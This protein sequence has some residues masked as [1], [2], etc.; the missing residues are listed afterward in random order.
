[1]ASPK[2]TP[3]LSSPP[4]F[5]V[6][7][8]DER[9]MELYEQITAIRTEEMKTVKQFI[10]VCVAEHLAYEHNALAQQ[11]MDYLK[12]PRVGRPRK[13]LTKEDN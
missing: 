11:I 1:M 2:P 6:R 8:N 3:A 13:Q 7:L 4:N 5:Y 9:G 12:T 10:L